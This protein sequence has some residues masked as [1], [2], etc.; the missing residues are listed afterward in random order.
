M[1]RT[2]VLVLLASC[3]FYSAPAFAQVSVGTF[4]NWSVNTGLTNTM[5]AT[6]LKQS[7]QGAKSRPRVRSRSSAVDLNQLTFQS[8]PAVSER[9]QRKFV[10]YVRRVN[11]SGAGR[12]ETSLRGRDVVGAFGKVI[13]PYGLQANNLGDLATSYM[14]SMWMIAN[15]GE[16]PQRSQVLAVQ[17]QLQPSMAALAARLT[18]EQRQELGEALIYE[19]FGAL[20][21]RSNASRSA[22]LRQQLADA[23]HRNFQQQGMDFRSMVLTS[24]GF[25]VK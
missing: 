23:T 6:I 25:Q 10:D 18:N 8:Q 14:V 24:S 5:N 20:G 9:V 2:N 19:T 22:T 16:L 1:R 7:K 4:G 12:L 11:P 3:V 13:S 15:Q 21:A 17:Q